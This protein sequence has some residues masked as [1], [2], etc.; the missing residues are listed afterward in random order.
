MVYADTDSFVFIL[1]LMTFI[2]TSRILKMKRVFQII[3]YLINAM[4]LLVKQFL[5]HIRMNEVAR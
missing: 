2:K 1:T 5:E 3:L 4:L